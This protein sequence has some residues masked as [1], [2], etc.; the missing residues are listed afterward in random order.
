MKITHF[1]YNAFLIEIENKK[2]AIDPGRDFWLF[3]M[4]K[5]LIPE[6]EWEGVTH[7]F[8]T[9]GDPDHFDFAAALAKKSGATVVCG[10]RLVEDLASEHVENVYGL[11]VGETI[12]VG[13]IE[14]KALKAFHGELPVKFPGF[15]MRCNVQREAAGGKEIYIAGKRIIKEEQLMD[16]YDHGSIKLFGGFIRLEKDN[17]GFAKGSIG[18]EIKVRSKKIVALGDTYLQEEWKDLKPNVLLIPIGGQNTMDVSSA[19]EA[20][21]LIQPE[22]VIPCHY[23]NPAILVKNFNPADDVDFKHKVENL[24]I[25]C[26]ILTYNESINIKL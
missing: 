19:I 21:K 14:T 12:K 13:G 6:S 26:E 16:V 7:L 24:G 2:I 9:H 3:T 11:K 4:N 8:I 10:E 25:T 20:V 23:N 15:E 18:F 1:L 5:S 17:V 22:L